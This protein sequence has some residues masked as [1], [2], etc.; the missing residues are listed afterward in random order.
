MVV[1]VNRIISLELEIWES[2]GLFGIRRYDYL[3]INVI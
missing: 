1:G 3:V 2:F